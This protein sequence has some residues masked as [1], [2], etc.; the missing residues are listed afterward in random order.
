MFANGIEIFLEAVSAYSSSMDW[1][2]ATSLSSTYNLLQAIALWRLSND[3]H[4]VMERAA[5][6]YYE[7]NLLRLQINLSGKYWPC[8]NKYTKCISYETPTL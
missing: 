4:I 2:Y 8:C 6:Q 7:L 1:T 5:C 3:T